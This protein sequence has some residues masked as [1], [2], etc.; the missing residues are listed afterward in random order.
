MRKKWR[1][2]MMTAVSGPIRA[3][4]GKRPTST[5]YGRNKWESFPSGDGWNAFLGGSSPPS[6]AV[7]SS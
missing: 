3:L 2:R 7:C 1:G 6:L 5:G 4:L